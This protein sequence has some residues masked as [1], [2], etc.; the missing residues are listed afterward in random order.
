MYGK[1]M[2]PQKKAFL[3]RRGWPPSKKP[4]NKKSFKTQSRPFVSTIL[5]LK[6]GL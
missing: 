3:K 1:N 2:G 6:S 5:M 4:K